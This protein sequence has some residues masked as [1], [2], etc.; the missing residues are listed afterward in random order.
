MDWY[1]ITVTVHRES[2]EALTEFLR[3]LGVSGVA[4][5]DSHLASEA[6]TGGWADIVDPVEESDLVVLRAYVLP[7]VV[8]EHRRALRCFVSRLSSFG[9]NPGPGLIVTTMVSDADWAHAWKAHFHV[10]HIGRVVVQ[11]SWL[12]YTRQAGEVVVKLDPGMAFGTGTH[13][14][15]AM[16][17]E[18]LP[19]FVSS[20]SRVWD[21]GTGSGILA[22]TAAKLGAASVQAV[23]VDSAA[24]TAAVANA[25]SNNVDVMVRKGTIETLDGQ[26]DFIVAN[27][28]ADVILELLPLVH[29]KLFPGGVFLAS[30]IVSHR[31]DEVREAAAVHGLVCVDALMSGEW[32]AQVFGREED[33]SCPGFF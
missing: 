13:P 30:G 3:D 18:L 6:R 23:D 15:T 14:S 32:T 10:L 12:A 28:I 7:D 8:D 25:E 9:L 11:P 2:E 21:V 16:C 33:V 20:T 5:E 1:E 31:S 29:R 17:V 24:V 27:I 19:R 4:I 26:A 22:V